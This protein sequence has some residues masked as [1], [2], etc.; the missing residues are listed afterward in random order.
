M[1]RCH[2]VKVGVHK[3][4]VRVIDSQYNAVI[5]K[6]LKVVESIV[7]AFH[8]KQTEKEKKEQKIALQ[9]ALERKARKLLG[10][11]SSLGNRSDKSVRPYLEIAHPKDKIYVSIETSIYSFQLY[12]KILLLTSSYRCATH[13]AAFH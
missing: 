1:G 11:S 3:D 5:E 9:V 2:V 13:R 4:V 7:T 10:C 8:G 6:S 12:T